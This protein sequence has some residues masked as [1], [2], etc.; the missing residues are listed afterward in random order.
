LFDILKSQAFCSVWKDALFCFSLIAGYKEHYRKLYE[1]DGLIMRYIIPSLPKMN[2]FEKEKTIYII[3]ASMLQNDNEIFLWLLEKQ[4]IIGLLLE[5]LS[6][7]DSYT[8]YCETIT[9]LHDILSIALYTGNKDLE[10]LVGNQYKAFDGEAIIDN[11]LSK[12]KC[13]EL[14]SHCLKLKSLQTEMKKKTEI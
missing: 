13:E 14:T 10:L 11:F 4:K 7:D 9:C 3:K 8:L 1:N 5:I 12:I 6:K 2:V